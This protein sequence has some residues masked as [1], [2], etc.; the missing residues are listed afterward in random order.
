MTETQKISEAVLVRVVDYEALY[1]DGRLMSAASSIDLPWE[2]DGKTVTFTY[3]QGTEADEN[4]V[5]NTGGFPDTWDEL[6][7]NQYMWDEDNR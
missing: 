3:R 7:D 6:I 1:I 5:M 4:F 2:L